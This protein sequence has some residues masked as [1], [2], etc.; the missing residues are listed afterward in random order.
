M[1]TPSS[2][3]LW[4]S[5]DEHPAPPDAAAPPVQRRPSRLGFLRNAPW[6]LISAGFHA[7]LI[8]GTALVYVERLV[9]VDEGAVEVVLAARAG[10]PVAELERP[11]DVFERKGI[12]KDDAAA[13]LSDEP[14]I[15]FP[16]AKES[17]HNESADGEDYRQMK[18]ESKSFL[19]YTPG[20]AGGFRG[21]QA[22]KIAGVN[23]AVGV[24]GGG[25]ASGR[26][27]ARFGGRE[28]LV[29][30][31]GG[32]SGTEDA[33]RAAM[34]WLSRHQSPDGSWAA[35][36]FAV[37]CAGEKCSGPG[38]RDFDT[39]DTGLA[40]LAFL[41]AGYSHLS[42][43]EFADPARPGKTLR[44]GDTV[45]NGLKWL[46]AQQDVDG[47]V[48]PKRGHYMYDHAIATL[49]LSEAY[50]MTN[51][52]TLQI[53][54]QKAVDFLIAAQNLGKGWRYTA[55]CGDNDTSVTGWAAMALKSA[56][57]SGLEFPRSSYD[58]TRAWFD[59]VT[60]GTYSRVGYTRKAG[61]KDSLSMTAI[62]VMCRI[63]MDKNKADP[64]L[65]SGC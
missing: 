39:G 4:R 48:G 15:F 10:G 41:G 32:G 45:K 61:P 63:F 3:V 50:G 37:Q 21:R 56:D 9:E 44:F 22:G 53:P 14:A 47:C 60:E 54:A 23:D 12:P 17:D 19:S 64:R 20:E 7:V 65:S 51:A 13:S 55:R 2:P 18:G 31:G 8:L 36:G 26:Y 40:L 35:A 6:W 34:R 46:V 52:S 57:L 27:G 58:G 49:A 29:A 38:G 24:G 43:D 33:V 11:R 28:N 16:E 1:S 5:I 30:K 59:E 42:R 25:G 62:G